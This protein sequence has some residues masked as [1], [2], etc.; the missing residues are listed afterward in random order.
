[1]KNFYTTSLKNVMTLAIGM[2]AFFSHSNLSAQISYYVEIT[3]NSTSFC[4]TSCDTLELSAVVWYNGLPQ[5]PTVFAWEWTGPN[6]V[7][8][9]EPI[10]NMPID[11]I[12]DAGE[13]CV[14]A[15]PDG[16]INNLD[17]VE[18][19]ID[20]DVSETIEWTCPER[21]TVTGVDCTTD[22]V[23]YN[24]TV[25]G[26]NCGV[27]SDFELILYDGFTNGI[28]HEQ[29]WTG[30][31]GTYYFGPA[32]DPMEYPMATSVV[33]DLPFGTH[34]LVNTV[35]NDADPNKV[36]AQCITEVRVVES[37]NNVACNDHINITL[38]NAC[39]AVITPDMILQGNI[40][41]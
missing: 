2:I 8:G 32:A 28:I 36:Y 12:I 34:Q 23:D 14:V 41:L 18:D 17:S 38:T 31:P 29:T 13:Y 20:V 7:I 5:P 27:T 30:A 25:S 15:T 10:I 6:G 39:E 3:A 22:L 24:F 9:D 35:Y 21:I 16:S 37:I 33:E 40:L 1:M 26:I 11:S 19:C 4:N